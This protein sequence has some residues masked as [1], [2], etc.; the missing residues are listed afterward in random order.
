M[1]I[2]RIAA[3]G[4]SGAI[5]FAATGC[6]NKVSDRSIQYVDARDAFTISQGKT[7]ILG[8]G[9]KKAIWIDPRPEA[10]FR[11]EHIPGAVHLPINK[12]IRGDPLLAGYNVFIVYGADY[13]SPLA[14]AM[15]KRL[16]ALKYNDVR[17]LRG[18]LRAWKQAGHA[19][20]ST[21]E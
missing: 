1:R 21:E 12:A 18:G 11:H 8:L 19:T 16:L 10:D 2:N 15:T 14:A 4:L 5:L 3:V 13:A 6:G 7:G 20:A 9:E 17:T